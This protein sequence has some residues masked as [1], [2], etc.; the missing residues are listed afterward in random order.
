VRAHRFIASFIGLAASL[1]GAEAFAQGAYTYGRGSVSLMQHG[2]LVTFSNTTGVLFGGGPSSFIV[3]LGGTLRITVRQFLIQP[4]IAFGAVGGFT[5]SS[6][7]GLAISPTL[8]IGGAIALLPNF[9]LSPMLRTSVTIIPVGMNTVVIAPLSAELPFTIFVGNNGI[10]EPFVNVGA[11]F[12]S[13]GGSSTSVFGS[14]GF[15][16][17]L[18][19]QF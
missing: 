12:V 19:V 8:G 18:G 6:G 17:R 9:A 10:I 2:D 16:Y 14:F 15:G 7:V 11:L 4:G 13:N 1:A 5:G 3:G